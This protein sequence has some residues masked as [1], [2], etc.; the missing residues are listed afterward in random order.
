MDL[1]NVTSIIVFSLGALASFAF[2][3][4]LIQEHFKKASELSWVEGFLSLYATVWFV[5]NLA[6]VFRPT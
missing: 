2:S 6:F 5:F 3:V 1:L 4:L